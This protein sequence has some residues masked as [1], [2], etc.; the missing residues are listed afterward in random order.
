MTAFA[1]RPEQTTQKVTIIN[2]CHVHTLCGMSAKFI[3]DYYNIKEYKL[4]GAQ[5]VHISATGLNVH[6][7]TDRQTKVKIVYLPVSLRSLGSYKYLW[8]I[9][10]PSTLSIIEDDQEYFVAVFLTEFQHI[11]RWCLNCYTTMNNTSAW[12]FWINY[13]PNNQSPAR[14]YHVTKTITAVLHPQPHDSE[15]SQLS[16]FTDGCL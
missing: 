11:F 10:L 1:H 4:E 16:Q 14:Y 6:R 2:V 12:H 9:D 8:R 5:R 7:H 3:T 15:I 13:L